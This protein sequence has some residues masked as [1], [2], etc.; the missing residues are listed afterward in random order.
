MTKNMFS[1]ETVGEHSFCFKWIYRFHFSKLN[2]IRIFER[3]NNK[4]IQKWNKIC[5]STD[6]HEDHIFRHNHQVR[7][8]YMDSSMM[9]DTIINFYA[10]SQ[11]LQ[12]KVNI[13]PTLSFNII[14][15]RKLFNIFQHY[16]WNWRLWNVIMNTLPFDI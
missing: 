2:K 15:S 4:S 8:N 9:N 16:Y 1:M 7:W 6:S 13:L 3:Q 5:I 11:A 12:L 10:L 14:I